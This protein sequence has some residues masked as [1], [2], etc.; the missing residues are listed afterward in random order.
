MTEQAE[1]VVLS[2]VDD[3]VLKIHIDN[4]TKK[5]AFDPDMML[6]LSNALTEL[7]NNPELWVGVITAEGDNFTAGLD[8][9]KFFGPGANPTPIPKQ[10]STP[11]AL[12]TPAKNLLSQPFKV[13]ALPSVLR[14]LWP[15]T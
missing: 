15:A 10:I 8:M 5:N 7:H 3:H 4:P 13:F 6:Q 11:S 12:V 2:E 14:W 1:G 9:P